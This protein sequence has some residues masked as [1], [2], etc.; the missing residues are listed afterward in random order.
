M[1]PLRL[2][3]ATALV[4]GTCLAVS[5]AARAQVMGDLS[6]GLGSVVA[7]SSPVRPFLDILGGSYHSGTGEEDTDFQ[8][9]YAAIQAGGGVE[10]RRPASKHGIRLSVHDRHVF[11]DPGRGQ[12]R[13]LVSY[14]F[15]LR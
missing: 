3:G 10:G 15:V 1:T 4:T 6:A 7:R 5:S 8:F 2:L 13:F 9:T 12:V 11:A 14:V